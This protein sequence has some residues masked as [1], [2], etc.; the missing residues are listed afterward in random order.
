MIQHPPRGPAW[1]SWLFVLL[2]WGVIYY[3]VPV[4]RDIREWMVETVTEAHWVYRT[5]GFKGRETFTLIVYAFAAVVTL[6]G[7]V[8]LL[9]RRREIRWTQWA[10]LLGVGVFLAWSAARLG[11]KAPEEAIHFIEYGVLSVLAFRAVA[12][13]VRDTSACLSA[14]MIA[15]LAGT[16]DEMIQ[17][18]S[19][20][21][22]WDFRDIW[23]NTQ[24]ALAG[25][26]MLWGGLRPAY[27]TRAWSAGGAR[28]AAWMATA[29]A[30]VLGFCYANTPALI[31]RYAP[32]VPWVKPF[33]KNWEEMVEYGHRHEVDGLVYQSRLS[34]EAFA[35]QD[36]ARGRE[37]ADI[38]A[39]ENPWDSATYKVFLE[40]RYP[41]TRDP[42]LYEL[43]VRLF[44]RDK[45]MLKYMRDYNDIRRWAQIAVR[46]QAILAAAFPAAL[47]IPPQ[48]D[49]G[50]LVRAARIAFGTEYL[51]PLGDL[52]STNA[53]VHVHRPQTDAVFVSR[54]NL[55]EL[56]AGEKALREFTGWLPADLGPRQVQRKLSEL[57]ASG[58]GLGG[59]AAAHKY[60][61]DAQLYRL[62][63]YYHAQANAEER[64][65]HERHAE[66]AHRENHIL[67]AQAPVMMSRFATFAP[68]ET[69][70]PRRFDAEWN[71]ALRGDFDGSRP[72]RSPV[73]ESLITGF[74]LP[75]IWALLAAGPA[76][77]HGIALRRRRSQ[78]RVS[79]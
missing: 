51:S 8:P 1:L 57:V 77:L 12:H 26:A 9:R 19:P 7:L 79:P 60:L 41:S 71:Q 46:E 17:W 14:A 36:R 64:D 49:P 56:M 2:W 10:W 75:A 34:G 13:R 25:V 66:W 69:T 28:L 58:A 40:Q 3:T 61:R 37:A 45:Y 55:A 50:E 42:Y 29:W 59:E 47:E 35:E 73:G 62:R 70:L 16:G 54:F 15:G 31:A 38:L 78:E 44:R 68:F 63:E 5:F 48:A 53:F 76:V 65:R 21:R 4:S 30:M 43:R 32:H 67:E 24:A 23:L 11:R 33:S 72:Y 74:S 27:V 20:E 18:I 6:A 52:M 22:S 39:K